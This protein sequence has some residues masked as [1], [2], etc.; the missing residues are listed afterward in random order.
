M[1]LMDFHLT[2]DFFQTAGSVGQEVAHPRQIAEF[3]QGLTQKKRQERA[4]ASLAE[5]GQV[6]GLWVEC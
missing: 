2:A 3:L 1:S 4:R 6:L 5:I